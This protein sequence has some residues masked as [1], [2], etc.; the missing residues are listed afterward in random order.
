MTR[1][2]PGGHAEF[3]AYTQ[4][5]DAPVHQSPGDQTAD[6]GRTAEGITE[7]GTAGESNGKGLRHT[8]AVTH[9]GTGS[10]R[11]THSKG[12][13]PA[14]PDAITPPTMAQVVST[15]PPTCAV[16]QNACA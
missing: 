11:A 1:E 7:E 14:L 10:V 15:S 12:G 13:V 16:V 5:F 4:S 3:P 9:G 2:R 8:A 6:E